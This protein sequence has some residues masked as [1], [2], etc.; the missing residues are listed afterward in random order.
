M[1]GAREQMIIIS[2]RNMQSVY[3]KKIKKNNNKGN[4]SIKWQR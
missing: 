1:K 2:Q 3:I 4:E